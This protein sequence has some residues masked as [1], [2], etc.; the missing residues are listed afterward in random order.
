V[1]WVYFNVPEKQYLEYMAEQPRREENKIELVLANGVKFPQ[2]GKIGA[3]DAK[4]DR[5]TGNIAFRADFSNPD[6]LLRHGQ[7]GTVLISRNLENVIVIPQRAVF[8]NLGKPCVYVVDNVAVAHRRAIEIQR[9]LEDIFVIKKG[10]GVDEK[11]VLE[12]TEQLRDGE[13][14]EYEFRTPDEVLKNLKHHAD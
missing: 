7:T 14:V 11:I 12:G 3:M 6:G 5:A 1:L 13:K 9:E 10:V 8:E 2:P 4:F